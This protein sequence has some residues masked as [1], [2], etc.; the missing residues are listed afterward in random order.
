MSLHADSSMRHITVR[1]SSSTRSQLNTLAETSDRTL[2][3]LI[4]YA[5]T[6]YSPE[7]QRP[8]SSS[9]HCHLTPQDG[10]TPLGVRLP[11]KVLTHL[12]AIAQ[13]YSVT[14][15]SVIRAALD[16]W[17]LVADPENLGKPVDLTPTPSSTSS[18]EVT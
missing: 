12:E 11:S 16:E 8:P 2:S 9:K 14:P 7:T 1:L 4:R 13:T 10:A 3:Q 15:S 18:N 5:I 6:A 17:L